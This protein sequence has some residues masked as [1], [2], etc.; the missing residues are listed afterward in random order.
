ME[1]I[2][3]PETFLQYPTPESLQLVEEVIREYSGEFKKAGIWTL[4]QG[5]MTHWTFCII[6]S[7]LEDNL[8]IARDRH[9]IVGWIH[10]PKM[11]EHYASRPELAW[12]S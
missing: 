5:K 9:G 2:K 4:L 12:N 6:F 1:I 10:N 3:Q 7:Y 11:A 8:Y